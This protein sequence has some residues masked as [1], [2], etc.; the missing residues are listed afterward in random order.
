MCASGL[1]SANLGR[2]THCV[3]VFVFSVYAFRGLC[4][5]VFR[6]SGPVNTLEH[7]VFTGPL[8]GDVLDKKLC[9]P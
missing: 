1:A 5:R 7:W 3:H 2:Q 8:L 4:L 9:L 6:P